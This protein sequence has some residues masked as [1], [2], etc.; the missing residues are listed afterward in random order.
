MTKSKSILIYGTLV[1][2]FTYYLILGLIKAQN[3][4]I[5]LVTAG[6]LSLLVLPVAQKM[7]KSFL[8][9]AWASLINTFLLLLVSFGFMTLISFQVKS[10]VDDWPEIK[11]TMAP[12]VEQLKTFVMEHTPMDK[13]SLQLKSNQI[14]IFQKSGGGNQSSSEGEQSSTGESSTSGSSQSSSSAQQA[15]SIFFGFLGFAG[16]F[17]L[18]FIYIFF[19]LNY[20]RRFRVFLLKVFPDEKSEEVQKVIS[21]SAQVAQQYLIGKLFLIALLAVLYTLGLGLSGVDNFI[22]VSVIAAALSLIPYVGNIIGFGMAMTFGYLTSGETGVL[23]G[24][25]I[26][27][28][29]AQFVESYIL[30]PYVVG[31]KVDLH[32]FFVILAVVI[33][34]MIW[35]VMGMI[36]S[37]PVLAIINVILLD[38]PNLRPFGFLLSNR[39]VQK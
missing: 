12:K 35:G 39:S 5:P 22:L 2:V 10:I 1:V 32:P 25:I 37:I 26:T 36:L 6:I 30:E 3:F 21:R 33:G 11:E 9:R 28:S 34:N 7:E 13:E 4:L 24:I 8:N 18:T 29:I 17:L 31:D 23:I 14:P 15:S 20:R 19:L 38:I 16:N 27:F